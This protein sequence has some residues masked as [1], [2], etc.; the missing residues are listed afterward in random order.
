MKLAD[1]DFDLPPDL[2][3][4]TPVPERDQSRLMVVE[5]KTSRILHDTFA[6]LGKYLSDHPLMVFNDTKVFPAKLSGVHK[7]TEK[8]IEILLVREI[9]PN[10]WE[11]LIKGL[12]RMKPG[13]QFVFAEGAITATLKGRNEQFG[14][15]SLDCRGPLK[16]ILDKAAK[17]PLPP[18]IDRNKTNAG[19]LDALD[20]SRYQTVFAAREGAI[21]APT[22]GLHFTRELLDRI[23]ADKADL[24]YLTLHVGVG[25]FMP[26]RT[27]E[28]ENHKMHAEHYFIAKETWNTVR[29]AKNRGQTI[30][31]V[32]TTVTRVLESLGFDSPASGDISGWTNKFLIPGAKFKSVNHLLTNFH[33]PRSTLFMLVCAFSDLGLMQKA[34]QQAI[35]NR[36]R[37]FSYGDAMLIL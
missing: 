34:Y 21:A 23:S 18:Y 30:L 33:L 25:T 4:Q 37:F 8:E 13:A 1:F 28:V 9:E 15:L 29:A 17:M 24:A 3:A 31:A 22:A 27:E 12:G 10:Q 20:R 26:V 5:R 35:E 16:E 14:I 6:N 11:A 19:E 2:I 32:G 36:Y 7:D